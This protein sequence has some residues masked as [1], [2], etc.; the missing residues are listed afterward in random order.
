MKQYETVNVRDFMDKIILAADNDK[1]TP[2]HIKQ[3]RAMI[4]AL[5]NHS[6]SQ[7]NMVSNALKQLVAAYPE[8]A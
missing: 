5:E 1:I 6:D 2:E 3:C 7:A 4:V 8:L